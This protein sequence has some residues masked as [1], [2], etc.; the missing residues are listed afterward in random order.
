MIDKR[1]ANSR[2]RY[3]VTYESYSTLLRIIDHYEE[4]MTI[5]GSLSIT[6]KTGCSGW[7]HE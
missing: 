5:S 1:L 3:N 2:S 7:G 4:V 6:S